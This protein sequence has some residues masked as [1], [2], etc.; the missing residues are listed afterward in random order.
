MAR[1][2]RAYRASAAQKSKT[3]QLS[4]PTS[5]VFATPVDGFVVPSGGAGAAL[6]SDA[7]LKKCSAEY[8]EG[9][10]HFARINSELKGVKRTIERLGEQCVVPPLS[11]LLPFCVVIFLFLT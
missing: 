3:K 1:L 6:T 7:Q 2:Y 5:A 9:R 8:R 4:A 11:P 10:K